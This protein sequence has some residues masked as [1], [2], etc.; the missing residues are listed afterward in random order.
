MPVD[1][2]TFRPGG[3]GLIQPSP[4]ITVE[5]RQADAAV[6]SLAARLTQTRNE[7]EKARLR[8]QLAAARR[9][10]AAA[11]A[12]AAASR[13]AAERA[14]AAAARAR[15]RAAAQA[16]ARRRAEEARRR[17]ALKNLRRSLPNVVAP[18]PKR[19][20]PL[21]PQPRPIP[22]APQPP[23]L[24]R[25][26]VVPPAPTPSIPRPTPRRVLIDRYVTQALPIARRLVA[27]GRRLRFAARFAVQR[28][29]TPP[30]FQQ[31]VFLRV[32]RL[33]RRRRGFFT[34]LFAP[35][36][37]PMPTVPTAPAAATPPP[38]VTSPDAI[39]NYMIQSGA[40]QP[41]PGASPVPGAAMPEGLMDDGSDLDE[42]LS[43]EE[44]MLEEPK[45]FYTRP[46]FLIGAAGAAYY[47]YTRQKK[48]S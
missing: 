44:L 35:R 29:G 9:R 46:I 32:R 38:V 45:P 2:S 41:F 26:R 34:R 21:F 39:P 17:Q 8:A 6:A 19:Q 5:Q 28:V 48:A 15:T 16:A 4:Q 1:P 13:R 33:L 31:I 23:V 43:D 24:R 10:A 37:V 25:R 3:T 30:A 36:P 42:E 20:L 18:G 40:F 47:L 11:R 7:A 22:S 12:R 27:R 14:R